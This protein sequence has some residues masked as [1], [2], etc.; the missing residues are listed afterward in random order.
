MRRVRQGAPALS[1]PSCST[2][3]SSLSSST[4]AS[5]FGARAGGAVGL[6][7]N[8]ALPPRLFSGF[9]SLNSID[10]SGPERR[11]PPSLQRAP[12]EQG[13]MGGAVGIR[14]ASLSRPCYSR[15]ARPGVLRRQ[16]KIEARRY[17]P[18]S[19]APRPLS[20]ARPPWIAAGGRESGARS[21]LGALGP[22]DHRP[23]RRRRPLC[24][25]DCREEGGG[26]GER[27]RSNSPLGKATPCGALV[28]RMWRAGR[29]PG[30][31]GDRRGRGPLAHR[32]GQQI[33]RARP[34]PRACSGREDTRQP[35]SAW[36]WV[37]MEA[38]ARRLGPLGRA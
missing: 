3:D 19:A 25:S 4:L 10:F 31:A 23:P 22:R 9:S 21:L 13:V 7:L 15:N 24:E 1:R 5:S 2:L 30:G 20:P 8:S 28:P 29:A 38:M 32:G 27:W 6:L 33:V 26:T 35:A 34:F 16:C 18:G 17:R 11:V 37:S 14:G 36:P 12:E